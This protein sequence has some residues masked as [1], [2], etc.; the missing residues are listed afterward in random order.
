MSPPIPDEKLDELSELIFRRRKIEAIKLY[1]ELTSL[2][3][4]EAKDAID[5]LELT[6]KK[7]FPKN[8][9]RAR[10]EKAALAAQRYFAS[11][12]SSVVVGSFFD[13]KRAEPGARANDHSC[14][15]PCL[16]TARASCGR[17]SSL[18]LGT[19]SGLG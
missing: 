17:G 5:A 8:S 10:K 18:T 3:L 15:D 1:R 13:D 11:S 2:G 7:I 6:L 4:K 16:R 12:S 19:A 9:L 14:H